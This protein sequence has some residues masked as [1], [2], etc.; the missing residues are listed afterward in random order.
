MVKIRNELTGQFI[1]VKSS[2]VSYPRSKLP[3]NVKEVIKFYQNHGILRK[4][5]NRMPLKLVDL[6]DNGDSANE[7]FKLYSPICARYFSV[8]PQLCHQDKFSLEKTLEI[9]YYLSLDL[10]CSSVAVMMGMVKYRDDKKDV[11]NEP[12]LR[13]RSKT[14]IFLSFC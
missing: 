13:I 3:S 8:R 10:N 14:H 2:T 6:G 9:L 1:P 4:L 7:N 5:H 11:N 12:I